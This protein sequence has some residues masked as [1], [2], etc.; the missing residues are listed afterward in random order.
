MTMGRMLAGFEESRLYCDLMAKVGMTAFYI[1]AGVFNPLI[2][3]V[4][5]LYLYNAQTPNISLSL[6]HTMHTHTS[7]ISLSLCHNSP[8][9]I[10]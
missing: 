6:C 10:L 1:H 8:L 3:K 2:S 4:G 9:K 5:L 7:K